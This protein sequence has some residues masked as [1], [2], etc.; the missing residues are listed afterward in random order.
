MPETSNK[1]VAHG[2]VHCPY[3]GSEDIEGGSVQTDNRVVWQPVRCLTCG[4][5]WND[6]YTIAG[7]E[8][9]E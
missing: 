4:R 2:G 8:P 1:Y 3:C 9:V 5:K 6:L 7:Y